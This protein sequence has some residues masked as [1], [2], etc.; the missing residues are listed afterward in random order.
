MVPAYGN[1]DIDASFDSTIG[2]DPN[3][4]VIMLSPGGQISHVQDAFA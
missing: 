1:L 2:N 4:A 3:A